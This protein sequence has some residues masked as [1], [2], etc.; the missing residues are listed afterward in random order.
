MKR[1]SILAT[2]QF[3][4]RLAEIEEFVAVRSEPR[5]VAVV[6]EIM[7]HVAK[8]KT[9]PRRG[10]MVPEILD[11]N[12]R[13]LIVLREYRLLYRVDDENRRVTILSVISGRRP[14]PYQ[15]V[16]DDAAGG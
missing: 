4:H 9:L 3:D 14:F 12:M 11:D 1:Y 2:H 6:A 10:R 8:L 5:A 13:E 16:L 7:A 15:D